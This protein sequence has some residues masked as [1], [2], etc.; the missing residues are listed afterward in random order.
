MDKRPQSSNLHWFWPSLV[1]QLWSKNKNHRL[2][3][4]P[5]KRV[6]LRQKAPKK[7][8]NSRPQ[9]I[10]ALEKFR[11]PVGTWKPQPLGVGQ[12]PEWAP[13]LPLEG[14]PSA[15]LWCPFLCFLK[16]SPFY[17]PWSHLTR[18]L[19]S[20]SLQEESVQG[21]WSLFIWLRKL[22]CWDCFH[23]QTVQDFSGM[24]AEGVNQIHGF[25]GNTVPSEA[26]F[27]GICFWS[28]S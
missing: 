27:W 24:G 18:V 10:T 2:H 5:N 6:A 28:D 3:K 12:R 13:I 14:T 16:D 20:M 4:H 8:K 26:Y 1:W 11:N 15:V 9:T 17:S 7:L 21:L 22:S 19:A 23:F 25:F